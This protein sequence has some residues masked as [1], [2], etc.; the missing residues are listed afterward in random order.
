MPVTPLSLKQ[1]RDLVR[2]TPFNVT[3]GLRVRRVHIDGV[4]IEIALRPDLFNN[5]GTLHGGVGAT[6]ADAAVGI[7]I[8]RHFAGTRGCT[9]VEMKINYFRAIKEGSIVARSKLLRVGSN[10]VVGSVD[11]SDGTGRAIGVALVTYML[12]DKIGK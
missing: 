1:T 11:L 8:Q 4:T 3:V 12:L 6:I 5:A 7:A 2:S 9:T 10:I